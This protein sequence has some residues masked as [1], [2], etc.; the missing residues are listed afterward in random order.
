M[1][2]KLFGRWLLR[3]SSGP[4]HI[5]G[6]FIIIG[7]DSGD[8]V[9]EPAEDGTPINLDVTGVEWA[10]EF[11]SRF[12]SGDWEPY[13][14]DRATRFVPQQGLTVVFATPPPVKPSGAFVFA[15]LLVVHCLS[16]D[17]TLSPPI[18]PNPFDFSLPKT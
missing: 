1:P 17:P 16:K 7:S 11:Q 13:E 6:R 14:P 5:T 9:F 10:I 12:S 18:S 2:Q 8:G 4:S 15:N 3:A